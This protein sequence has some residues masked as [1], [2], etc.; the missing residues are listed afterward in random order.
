MVFILVLTSET[1]SCIHQSLHFFLIMQVASAVDYLHQK[2]ILHCDLKSS[3]VLVWEFP[4]PGQQNSNQQVLLKI[5]D[6]GISRVYNVTNQI[7]YGSIVGTP[8]FIAP[9]V[10]TRICKDLQS[11]KV[12][13]KII[14]TFV[15]HLGISYWRLRYLVPK[16]AALQYIL[17]TKRVQLGTHSDKTI[18]DMEKNYI[19][20]E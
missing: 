13:I 2:H 11:N 7:R 1:G 6:Y 16:A 19:P 14:R 10:Y 5:T 9:E 8:G 18:Y 20:M 17:Y 3:N 4:L 15:H 12:C